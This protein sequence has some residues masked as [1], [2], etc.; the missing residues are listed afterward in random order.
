MPF[1]SEKALTNFRSNLKKEFFYSLDSSLNGG[2]ALEIIDHLASIFKKNKVERIAI[3]SKN[4]CFWPLLY[5]AADSLGK[6]VF[7]L[8]PYFSEQKIEEISE[9]EI[10]FS[11]I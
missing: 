5:V 3:Y 4:N 8:N 10:E 11:V 9:N 2:E 7:I 1:V 6:N